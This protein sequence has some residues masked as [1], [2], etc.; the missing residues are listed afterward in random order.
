MLRHLPLAALLA[1]LLLSG[2]GLLG[3]GGGSSSD[4]RARL[5]VRNQSS[6]AIFFLYASPC[7][8]DSWGD[9]RLGDDVIMS[10]ASKSLQVDDRLL[11]LQG[12]HGGWR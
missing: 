8:N 5:V 10:N 2:C 11:G 4:E 3:L 12:S 6:Q 9:D 7:S 1:A